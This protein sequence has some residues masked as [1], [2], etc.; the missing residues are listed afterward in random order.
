M[1][2]LGVKSNRVDPDDQNDDN[3]SERAHRY[4][5]PLDDD[6]KRTTSG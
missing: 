2:N 4:G 5:I 3:D 6:N 1:Y